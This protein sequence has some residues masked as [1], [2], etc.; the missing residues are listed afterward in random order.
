MLK[1]E[2]PKT[3]RNQVVVEVIG[4]GQTFR[5]IPLNSGILVAI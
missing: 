5:R 3:Y 2:A 1:V 4:K